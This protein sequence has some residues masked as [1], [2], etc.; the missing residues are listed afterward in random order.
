MPERPAP[1]PEEFARQFRLKYGRDMTAA[2]VRFYTLTKKLLDNPP[3]K[4]TGGGE[5]A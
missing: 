3:E 2:E 4:D 5:A 1:T